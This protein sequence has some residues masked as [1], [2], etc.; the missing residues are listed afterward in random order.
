MYAS[1]PLWTFVYLSAVAVVPLSK[2]NDLHIGAD[3]KP[4]RYIRQC[5]AS[6]G[7]AEIRD[8]RIDGRRRTAFVPLALRSPA[9]S[10]DVLSMNGG[11]CVRR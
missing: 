1:F 9:V 11:R 5:L 4:Q 2:H 3:G 10:V 8:A 7:R 6:R